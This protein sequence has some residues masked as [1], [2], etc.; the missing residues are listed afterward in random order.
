MSGQQQR[1]LSRRRRWAWARREMARP[2]GFFDEEEMKGRAPRLFHQL[3]GRHVQSVDGR[4][5]QLQPMKGS[6]SAH[7]LQQLD[8]EYDEAAIGP[9]N[10]A[11]SKRCRDNSA[12]NDDVDEAMDEDGEVSLVGAAGIP[13]QRAAFLKAMRDRFIEGGEESVEYDRI[14]AD[15]D[16]DDLEIMD[17]DAE[18]KYFDDDS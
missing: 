18:E 14:D 7:L 6:L 15:S 12:D 1:K 9:Q 13:A 16:L 10:A 8:R 5:G 4:P 11:D 17:A 2:G 3:V